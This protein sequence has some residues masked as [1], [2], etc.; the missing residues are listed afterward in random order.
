MSAGLLRMYSRTR[1]NSL[2]FRMIR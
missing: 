2:L 1:S